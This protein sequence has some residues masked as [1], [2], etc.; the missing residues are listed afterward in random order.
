MKK[1][2]IVLA[3]IVA[4]YLN[5]ASWLSSLPERELTLLAHR[6]VHQNYSKIDL[7]RQECTAIRID[8]P[9]HTYL[10]NTIESIEKSFELGAQIVEID[11]HPTT[12][13]RFVVYHDWKLDCRTNAKGTVRKQSLAY[14]QSL[15]IGYGYTADGGKTYPFR[16]KF[17]GKMPSL[18]QVLDAFPKQR[19][20]VNFKSNSFGEGDL[21]NEF[22]AQRPNEDLSRLW[23]YGGEKPTQRLL[24]LQPELKGFTRSSVKTCATRYLLLGWSGYVPQSCR[25]TVVGVPQKYTPVV[26]GWPRTFI[27]RM[28]SVGTEVILTGTS[29]DHMDGLDDPKLIKTLA[30]DYRGIVWTD[31]IERAHKGL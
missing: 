1:I 24:E 3:V 10:E 7:G 11:I 31:K 25:D 22:L 23:F 2:A 13:R 8:E 19:F 20:L 4:V 12:D 5:N 17:V 14:L 6:G 15:D 28:D 18:S 27:N 16:G 26:W 30:E 29:E 9:E 21:V